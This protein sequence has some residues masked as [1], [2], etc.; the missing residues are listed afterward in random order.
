[1]ING[2]HKHVWEFVPIKTSGD[3]VESLNG[4]LKMNIVIGHNVSALV[5]G[6]TNNQRGT[7]SVAVVVPRF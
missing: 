7:T 2:H 4:N 5:H 1:M 3:V 6:Q